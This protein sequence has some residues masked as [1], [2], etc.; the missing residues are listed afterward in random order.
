[1]TKFFPPFPASPTGSIGILAN[2][3]WWKASAQTFISGGVESGAV[4]AIVRK[5]ERQFDPSVEDVQ[6]VLRLIV[7]TLAVSHGVDV[8]NFNSM[9]FAGMPTAIDEFIQASSRNWTYARWILD[10]DPNAA[11]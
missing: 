2:R 6:D 1:M 10:A 7:A 8:E 11:E 5:A 4:E 3:R 9:F